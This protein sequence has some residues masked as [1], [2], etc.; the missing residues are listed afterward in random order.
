M[1]RVLA[2]SSEF[3]DRVLMYFYE[4]STINADP[5]ARAEDLAQAFPDATETDIGRAIDELLA[6]GFIE[7]G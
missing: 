7:G 2:L 1:T 5:I 6:R 3:V 4:V